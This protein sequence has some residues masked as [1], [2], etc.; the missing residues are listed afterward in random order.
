LIQIKHI[1]SLFSF[2]VF[3]IAGFSK[4]SQS[5]ILILDIVE[6]YW[7]VCIFFCLKINI[8]DGV[9]YGL[10]VEIVGVLFY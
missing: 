8:G 2:T 9:G 5:T 1:L 10:K 3:F 7:I 4:V 6:I